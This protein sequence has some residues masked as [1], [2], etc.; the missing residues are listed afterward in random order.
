MQLTTKK[1]CTNAA[2]FLLFA[3]TVVMVFVQRIASFQ[4]RDSV[5]INSVLMISCKCMFGVFI[6]HACIP[7][8]KEEGSGRFLIA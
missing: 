2:L 1:G 7:S 3:H 5:F 8:L 4:A 6:V